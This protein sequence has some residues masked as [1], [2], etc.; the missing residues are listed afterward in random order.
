MTRLPRQPRETFNRAADAR[1]S[2][3]DHKASDMRTR[4]TQRYKENREAWVQSEFDRLLKQPEKPELIHKPK[5]VYYDHISA[6]RNKAENT[7]YRRYVG[8]LARIETA[9]DSMSESGASV[10]KS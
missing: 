7:I 5:G 1:I 2:Q 3:I 4:A 10:R 8:H 9:K 6:M